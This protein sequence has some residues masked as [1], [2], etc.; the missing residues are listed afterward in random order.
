MNIVTI[1]NYPDRYNENKMCCLF[2]DSI[3]KHNPNCN[4]F[5]LHVKQNKISG[6]IKKFINRNH[7]TTCRGHPHQSASSS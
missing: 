7:N 5:I 4:L 1:M 2:I 3:F 6:D